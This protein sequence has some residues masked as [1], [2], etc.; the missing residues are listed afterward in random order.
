MLTLS[1]YQSCLYKTALFYIKGKFMQMSRFN[2]LSGCIPFILK[3]NLKWNE[4]TISRH[5]K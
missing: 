2:I 3:Q 4:F 5:T 1:Q